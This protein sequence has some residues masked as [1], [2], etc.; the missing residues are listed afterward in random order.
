MSQSVWGGEYEFLCICE[1]GCPRICAN[2][3]SSVDFS[4]QVRS[5][6]LSWTGLLWRSWQ[7]FLNTSIQAEGG[8]KSIHKT[9]CSN[10]I[11]LSIAWN[12]ISYDHCFLG[13]DSFREQKN[14]E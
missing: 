14:G 1:D 10:I 9:I 11:F 6:S 12:N 3:V 4:P 8:G 13:F 7:M 5:I 2:L